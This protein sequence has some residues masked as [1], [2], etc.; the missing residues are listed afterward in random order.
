MFV[1][2]NGENF[3]EN[4]ECEN[5]TDIFCIYETLVLLIYMQHKQEIIFLMSRSALQN[6]SCKYEVRHNGLKYE[7][8]AMYP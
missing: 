5:V 2:R 3:E 6:V 4:V 7:V 1:N 8:L